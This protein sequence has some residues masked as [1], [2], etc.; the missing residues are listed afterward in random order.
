METWVRDA[1]CCDGGWP[2]RGGSLGPL[3]P[4]SGGILVR[5]EFAGSVSL[6]DG[7]ESG[8]AGGWGETPLHAEGFPTQGETR[9]PLVRTEPGVLELQIL[10]T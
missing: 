8:G 1:K 7:Q 5:R 3:S 10:G 4:T 6:N 9:T 2:S